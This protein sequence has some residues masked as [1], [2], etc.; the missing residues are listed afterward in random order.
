MKALE[1]QACAWYADA[2]IAVSEGQPIPRVA[3]TGMLWYQK[4]GDA[5]STLAAT[6]CIPRG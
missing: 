5:S 6:G 1:R 3:C 2:R 4:G